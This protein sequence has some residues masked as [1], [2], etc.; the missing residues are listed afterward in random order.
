MFAEDG[1]KLSG[2][3]GVRHD[4]S[5]PGECPMMQPLMLGLAQKRGKGTGE[6]LILKWCPDSLL[7][8]S[9][10]IRCQAQ[11]NTIHGRPHETVK[12]PERRPADTSVASC[13]LSTPRRGLGQALTI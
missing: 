4:A 5:G 3:H 12:A 9:H 13:C 10:I 2:E 8:C 6:G 11:V 7:P 1:L